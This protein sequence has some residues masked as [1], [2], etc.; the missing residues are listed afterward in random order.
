MET[1]VIERYLRVRKN[2]LT[3]SEIEDISDGLTKQNTKIESVNR[4]LQISSQVQLDFSVI[5]HCFMH[6]LPLKSDLRAQYVKK[7]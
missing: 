1:A 3:P 2:K 6:I 4:R 5:S 7:S